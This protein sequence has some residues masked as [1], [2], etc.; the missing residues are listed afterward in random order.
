[1]P[2]PESD[3]PALRR[4]VLEHLVPHRDPGA[5]G[6]WCDQWW[7]HP[8][9]LLR[10]RALHLSWLSAYRSGSPS[11]IAEWFL[12][13]DHHVRWLNTNDL[14][15]V[16]WCE[17]GQ[18]RRAI[19]RLGPSDPPEEWLK[20]PPQELMDEILKRHRRLHHDDGP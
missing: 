16:R 8:G 2:Q 5:G 19:G 14:S 1:V 17:G 3:V 12:L 9:V 10:F 11:V 18:H 4:W 6:Y 7:L 15:P 13:A 20:M